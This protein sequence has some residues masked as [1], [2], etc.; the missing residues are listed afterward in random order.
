MDF[1]QACILQTS[2]LLNN[3]EVSFD[4]DN[5]V[6]NDFVAEVALESE[7]DDDLEGDTLLPILRANYPND[8]ESGMV[9]QEEGK[10][11]NNNILFLSAGDE[12]EIVFE[13]DDEEVEQ[14]PILS[15]VGKISNNAVYTNNLTVPVNVKSKSITLET[16]IPSAAPQNMKSSLIF[17]AKVKAERGSNASITFQL[18]HGGS[19]C[20]LKT[21]VH[22]PDTFGI[23]WCPSPK[24]KTKSR[25][26]A[27]L[28]D[29]LKKT[30]HGPFYCAECGIYFLHLPSLNRHLR[31]SGHSWYTH[32]T[33]KDFR[34]HTVLA[35][36]R[37]SAYMYQAF[38]AVPG[39]TL[40]M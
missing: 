32:A 11:N 15:Q 10:S 40:I 2:T 6:D 18:G 29:H 8:D 26:R 37:F 20:Q 28:K 30:H 3:V 22:S 4:S 21:A 34:R 24:C 39:F 31:Q 9:V 36:E 7:D 33:N 35:I 25:K 19:Y 1:S 12:G 38:S 13:S 27:L 5:D 17:V 14:K 23:Y 16:T